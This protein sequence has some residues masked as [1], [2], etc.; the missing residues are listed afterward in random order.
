MK[1]DSAAWRG[2]SEVR[3][4]LFSPSQEI[5]RTFATKEG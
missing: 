5:I 3:G 2:E 4:W 1:D